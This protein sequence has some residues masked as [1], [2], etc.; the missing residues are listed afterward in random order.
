LVRDLHEE[1]GGDDIVRADRQFRGGVADGEGVPQRAD[2]QGRVLVDQV[3]VVALHDDGEVDAGDD[4]AQVKAAVLVLRVAVEL[5]VPGV[6]R[7]DV[8]VAA[9]GHGAEE[10]GVDLGPVDGD[11]G[12]EVALFV[13]AVQ[14]L[15]GTAADVVR[16]VAHDGKF[17]L[18][19]V[20]PGAEVGGDA[21]DRFLPVVAWDSF[22]GR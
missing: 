7:A 22:P 6:V 20:V 21:H 19:G 12:V 2:G 14:P 8:L 4:R 15:G 18:G 17:A 10:G 3:G 5:A 9:Q 11:H 16:D 13:D 1:G